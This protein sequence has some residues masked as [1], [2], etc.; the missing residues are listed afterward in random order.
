MICVKH[1]EKLL[2][3]RRKVIKRGGCYYTVSGII[4]AIIIMY[5]LSIHL[6]FPLAPLT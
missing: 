1:L 6:T 4:F 5:V 3:H 2:A